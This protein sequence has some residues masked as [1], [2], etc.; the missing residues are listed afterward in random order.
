[1]PTPDITK[2]E[3]L[4]DEHGFPMTPFEIEQL[5]HEKVTATNIAKERIRLRKANAK[6]GFDEPT[7]G[8]KYHVQLDGSVHRRG[9]SG[10]RFERGATVEITVV[11]DDE[12]AEIKARAPDAPV[13]TVEGAERIIEDTAL[14]VFERPP[15]ADDLD[16]LRRS[17]A[18]V[19]EELRAS[20]ADA[21][22]LRQAIAEMTARRNAPES[23]DGKPAKLQAQAAARAAAPAAQASAPATPAAADFGGPPPGDKK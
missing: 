2:P 22:K 16:A 4:V 1:M 14:H 12:H 7:V 17:H 3:T 15:A 9:R 5:R 6:K 19:E 8:Q 11:S 23:T 10:V 20:R 18:A 13:V 21:A